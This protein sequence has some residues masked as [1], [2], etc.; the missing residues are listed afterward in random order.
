LDDPRDQ[1]VDGEIRRLDP[2]ERRE[3]AAEHGVSSVLVLR[4]Q[5]HVPMTRY[6]PP[7]ST[8][9]HAERM[10]PELALVD[11]T[12][13]S[14]ARCALPKGDDTLARLEL[15]VRAH[16]ILQTRWSNG[17][18]PLRRLAIALLP[19]RESEAVTLRG[20]AVEANDARTV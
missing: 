20:A 14:D 10:S 15:L 16:R 11:A 4:H 9:Q 19:S 8:L 3:D 13:A 17:A 6:V 1:G 5:S 7:P 2:V 18:R 12:L